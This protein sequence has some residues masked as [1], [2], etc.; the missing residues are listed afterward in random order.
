MWRKT[1][2]TEPLPGDELEGDDEFDDDVGVV[3]ALLL[4]LVF[5]TIMVVMIMAATH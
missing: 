5:I 3:D 1:R 4:G 2:D